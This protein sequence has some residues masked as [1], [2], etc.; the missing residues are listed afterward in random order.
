MRQ[1]LALGSLLMAFAS[2]LPDPGPD[3]SDPD[4]LVVRGHIEGCGSSGRQ[5]IV[6]KTTGYPGDDGAAFVS[7]ESPGPLEVPREGKFSVLDG[8][9]VRAGRWRLFGESCLGQACPENPGGGRFRVCTA[10]R[11]SWWLDLVCLDGRGVEVC[12]A[13]ITEPVPPPR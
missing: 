6:M 1:L 5:P 7:L 3:P 8:E 12:R 11:T 9:R 2:C 10:T 13:R 4:E